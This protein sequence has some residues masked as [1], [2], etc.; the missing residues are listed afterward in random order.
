MIGQKR[1]SEDRFGLVIT[2]QSTADQYK[3][4]SNLEARIA[5][6]ER[7]STNRYGWQRWV[8]DQFDIPRAARVLELGCGV[9]SL[10]L[11][12]QD[13]MPPEWEVTLTDFSAG[14]LDK[15][16]K[17]LA[18]CGRPLTFRV[19]NAVDLPYAVEE[20]DIV[21]A[22]HMLYYVEPKRQAFYEIRRVLKPG[23]RLYATTVGERHMADLAD[24]LEAYDPALEYTDRAVLSFTLENGVA[25]VTG[26]FGD[27][28]LRRY[29]DALVVSVQGA[30]LD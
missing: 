28:E 21:I 6:H 22:N 15:A 24:L 1:V 2:P 10:W 3:G 5:L 27:V 14:M 20:F 4:P 7:F 18:H 8:F 23:G 17:N 16:R 12:N 29:E 19:V 13:R 26:W 25:Q 11:E 30:L 9:G